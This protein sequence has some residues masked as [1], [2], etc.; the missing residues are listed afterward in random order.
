MTFVD[1]I[2]SI[3]EAFLVQLFNFLNATL[4]ALFGFELTAPDLYD[5]TEEE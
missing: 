1:G 5:D 3:V 4:G 2:L